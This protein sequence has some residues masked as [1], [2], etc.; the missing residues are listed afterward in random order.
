MELP[1]MPS[2]PGRFY[3]QVNH[4]GSTPAEFISWIYEETGLILTQRSRMELP[5][6]PN[7]SQERF[8]SQVREAFH[9][10]NLIDLSGSRRSSLFNYLIN[11]AGPS[12]TFFYN[13]II[14]L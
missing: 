3:S 5:A 9:W 7:A 4:I 2:A 11:V 1:A 6:M 10:I 13:F 8:Y 14:E 12:A